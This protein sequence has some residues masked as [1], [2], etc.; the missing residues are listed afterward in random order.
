MTPC[1]NFFPESPTAI[2]WVSGNDKKMFNF[3]RVYSMDAKQESIFEFTAKPILED[4]FIGF[5][6]TIFAYGQTGAGKTFTMMGE[7]LTNPANMGI[8]PRSVFEIFSKILESPTNN[9]FYIRCGMMQIYNEHISD[10]IDVK[11]DNLEVREST[12]L[13]I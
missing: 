3:D 2:E 7:D 4:I 12:K 9:Q 1:C 6:G 11:K 8:I 10:L 5:N 13:G